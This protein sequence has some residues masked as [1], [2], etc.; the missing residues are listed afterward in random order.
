MILDAEACYD[1]IPLHIAALSL[2][3]QGLPQSAI[4]YM[5][6][7]IY[8]MKHTVRTSFGES[9]QCYRS[10]DHRLHG[11]LQG[12]GAGPCIWVM[13]STPL[14]DHLRA[15]QHGI[16]VKQI[17]YQTSL[18]IP[19]F[20]FV[21]DVDVVDKSLR[22]PRPLTRSQAALTTWSTDLQAIGGN[23]K[24]AKCFWQWLIFIWDG[25]NR[26]KLQRIHETDD[27]LI[28]TTADGT[29][30]TLQRKEVDA[31][32]L[33][34][35]IMFS[36]DGSMTDEINH[37]K[38]NVTT[39]CDRIRTKNVS[40]KEAW[41][42]MTQ[43]I[44]RSLHYPLM[45]TTISKDDMHKI[46][47]PLLE[48]VLP[49]AGYY[50]NIARDVV[51]SSTEH[52]GCG[53]QDPWV[54]QGLEKLLLILNEETDSITPTL[55]MTSFHLCMREHGLGPQFLTMELT[56]SIKHLITWGIIASLWDFCSQCSIKLQYH[57]APIDRF[58]GDFYLMQRILSITTS[59]TTL[60]E[61]NMS[62]LLAGG[63]IF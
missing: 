3:R 25:Q 18:L 6:S 40:K 49:K 23:L 21:D 4:Q 13:V 34:L 47:S 60:R 38:Q 57:Q 62:E 48:A 22:V 17:G 50:R 20:A 12:N 7:P 46:M 45:A 11:I 2:Q 26:W 1:R 32:T 10:I 51:F 19:A 42:A 56:P 54:S 39:Y 37:L 52:R 9:R 5:F 30:V 27:E 8:G 63:Y 36:V 16:Q 24:W 41:Y 14:L 55:L 53:V 28:I 61:F 31:A 29:A 58:N 33:A 59:K 35:G 15:Q 44:L 43:C